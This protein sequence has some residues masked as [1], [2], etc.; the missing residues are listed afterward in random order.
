MENL[1]GFK[2]A[3][4]KLQVYEEGYIS[5]KQERVTPATAP[6]NVQVTEFNNAT[7]QP[8]Q[9]QTEL[10]MTHW[11]AGELVKVLAEAMSANR[12]P[13]PEPSVFSG[14]S[15]KSKHWKA[16]FQTPML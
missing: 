11:S 14:H 15:L 16:S 6:A 13:I 9:Q 10:N 4:A 3:K 12:L 2:A 5:V 1:K 7:N 8:S